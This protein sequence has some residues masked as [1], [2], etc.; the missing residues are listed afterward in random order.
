VVGI[1]HYDYSGSFEWARGRNGVIGSD[2]GEIAMS[3]QGELSQALMVLL[4]YLEGKG[5]IPKLGDFILINVI[6][7]LINNYT[8]IKVKIDWEKLVSLSANAPATTNPLWIL[9]LDKLS[10]LGAQ[11]QIITELSQRKKLEKLGL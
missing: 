4:R 9:A 1:C 10:K 6:Q 11:T 5:Q 3:G 7:G 2:K 8:G